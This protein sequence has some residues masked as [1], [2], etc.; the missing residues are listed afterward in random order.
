MRYLLD[1][2]VIM[3]FLRWEPDRLVGRFNALPDDDVVIS[4]IVLS[5]LLFGI[6]HST[7]PEENRLRLEGF[8]V[9]AYD[10]DAAEHYSKIRQHLE[11]QGKTIGP[12]DTLIAAHARSLGV[13][14]VTNNLREFERVPDLIVEAW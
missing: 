10:G 3:E 9:M 6:E 7:K 2:S 12:M 5:E 11:Q 13:A 14:L 4:T 1:S 8:V